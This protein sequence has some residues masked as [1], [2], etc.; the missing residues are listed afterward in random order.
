MAVGFDTTVCLQNLE[1]IGNMN[2]KSD[3]A[4]PK[5]LVW[6]WGY[7]SIFGSIWNTLVYKISILKL[8]FQIN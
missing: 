8:K 3:I 2:R 1:P 4:H 6:D 5:F 7:Q